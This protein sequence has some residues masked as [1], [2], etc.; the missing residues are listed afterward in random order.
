MDVSFD[1]GDTR[2]VYRVVGVALHGDR[3]LIHRAEIDDFWSLPGGRPTLMESSEDALAREMHEEL[4]DEVC[5]RRLLWVVENFFE[6]VGRPHHEL[7]LY[8]LMSI[9]EESGLWEKGEEFDGDENGLR[10]IFRWC[11]IAS[12]DQIRIVP[13][14]LYQALTD[15]PAEP[16]HIVHRDPTES[17]HTS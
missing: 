3:V 13:S 6:Y 8:F 4:G 11:P 15:I 16:R 17:T 14:F 2:F 9:P 12:L 1:K 7:G 5:I 10:L